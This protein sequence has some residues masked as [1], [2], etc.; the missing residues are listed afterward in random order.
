MENFVLLC[1]SHDYQKFGDVDI[2]KSIFG[3]HI[4]KFQWVQRADNGPYLHPSIPITNTIYRNQMAELRRVD[5]TTLFFSF[6]S[7]NFHILGTTG[8]NS[9][10][11]NKLCCVQP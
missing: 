6:F 4:Y 8:S 10:D 1:G 5:P 11:L 3:N 7:F 2:P 9:Y